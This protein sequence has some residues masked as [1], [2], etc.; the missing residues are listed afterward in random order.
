MRVCLRV[1]AL[2]YACMHVCV[3]TH[4][5]VCYALDPRVELARNVYCEAVKL[6][7][8]LARRVI[9]YGFLFQIVSS[10]FG[11]QVFVYISI[12]QLL[13]HS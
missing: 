9:D 3:N 10:R 5:C 4:V 1:Y 8:Y 12:R 7:L 11:D 13:S 2:V 6:K